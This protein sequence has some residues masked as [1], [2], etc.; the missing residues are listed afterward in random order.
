MPAPRTPLSLRRYFVDS[1]AYL[2]LIDRRDQH[3]GEAQDV[4]AGLTANGYP[5]FTTTIVV[6]EAHALVLANLGREHARQFLL[7]SAAS[8]TR[9]VQV[10]ARDEAAGRA[11]LFRYT[12]KDWSFTDAISFAVVERLGIRLAFTFDDDFT[13]YGF[14]RLTPA[15]LQPR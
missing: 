8:D 6:I 14:T 13:Q 1:S 4:I 7:D 11:I 9:I 2:A 15:F 3:H 5:A 12:D 10:R